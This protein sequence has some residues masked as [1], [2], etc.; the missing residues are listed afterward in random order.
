MNR[1]L[2][3]IGA[4]T[5]G[6]VAYELACDMNQFKKIDFVDD[7]RTESP[8]GDII[9]GDTGDL[10]ALS[11]GYTDVIVAVGNPETRLQLLDRINRET[12]LHIATLVSPKAYI[13]PTATVAEGVIVEPFAVVH[14]RCEIQR[15]CLISAGAVINHESVCEEGVHV[16]CNASISG[17]ERVP[18]KTKVTCGTVYRNRMSDQP[19]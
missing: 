16:D 15:G 14:T 13:A 5:Y 11:A 2:L 10:V 6:L 17:Y 7:K 19:S 8:V 18:S 3:I 1:S 12:S 9:V 4:G